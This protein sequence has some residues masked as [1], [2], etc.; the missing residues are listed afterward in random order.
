MIIVWL[1][2]D[3]DVTC[4]QLHHTCLTIYY[5]M[6]DMSPQNFNLFLF[7]TSE[8][9]QF[10]K[11][12]IMDKQS[13]TEEIEETCIT[14]GKKIIGFEYFDTILDNRLGVEFC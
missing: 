9:S 1:E 11:I 5:F 7:Y 14:R 12:V 2:L 4:H 8:R 10:S 6:N 13:P 3:L